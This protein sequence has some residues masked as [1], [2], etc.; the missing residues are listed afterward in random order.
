[1]EMSNE[2]LPMLMYSLICAL[3]VFIIV[4]VYKL[5]VMLNKTNTLLDDVIVKVH[6]LDNLFEVIDK[7]T[8]TINSVTNRVSEG[9]IKFLFKIFKK[10][11]DDFDE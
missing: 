10:R 11:K 3:I 9:V 7:S 4:F 2:L 1:M 8:S 5:I 6:K